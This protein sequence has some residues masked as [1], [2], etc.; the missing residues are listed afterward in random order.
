MKY[1][2]VLSVNGSGEVGN[3]A[4]SFYTRTQAVE[5]C[6]NWRT[7]GSSYYAYLWDNTGSWT[8]YAPIP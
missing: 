1:K 3:A 5:A 7:L 8:I 6:E 2:V 4:V